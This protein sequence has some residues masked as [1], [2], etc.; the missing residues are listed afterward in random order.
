[1]IRR[2]DFQELRVDEQG[3]LLVPKRYS[4]DPTPKREGWEPYWVNTN[5][6]RDPQTVVIYR[7]RG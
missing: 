5:L 3:R 7:P 4:T 6:E 1:M 2:M